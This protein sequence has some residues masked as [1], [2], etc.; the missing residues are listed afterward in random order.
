MMKTARLS[1]STIIRKK[2]ADFIRISVL[3]V[4]KNYYLEPLGARSRKAHFY[5][6]ELVDCNGE[7]YIHK[8]GKLLINRKFDNNNTF[9][10]SY[11][12]SKECNNYDCTL[13]NIKCQKDMVMETIDLKKYY[14]TCREEVIIE[15][16]VADLLLTNSQDLN[17]LPILIEICVTHPCEVKKRNSG[18]KIIE[19]TLRKEQDLIFL[20]SQK[21]LEETLF[22]N[23]R[24][25]KSNL[26]LLNANY[27]YLW[28]WGILVIFSIRVSKKTV[29]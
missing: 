29:M 2:R 15:G 27:K 23:I 22:K 25:K 28:K 7:T 19:L 9:I 14:D 5:H 26:Y 18:L 1:P 4:E 20:L 8:L 12:V 16:F 3:A 24:K 21:A 11:P 10:V 6:K 13:R 17:I